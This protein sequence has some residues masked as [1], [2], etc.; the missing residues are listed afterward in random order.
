MTDMLSNARVPA[1]RPRLALLLATALAAGLTAALMLFS[2]SAAASRAR[3]PR[4]GSQPRIARPG[5][6]L[7]G[8]K[9]SSTRAR[10]VCTGVASG[11]PAPSVAHPAPVEVTSISAGGTTTTTTSGGES[12]AAP[13]QAP[14]AGGSPGPA[15]EP[16]G[17]VTDPIDPRYL[18]SLPFGRTS[19]WVQPWRAY[20]DTWPASRLLSSAGVNFNVGA[21]NSDAVA[22]LLHDD[23]FTLARTNLSWNG[24]SYSDPTKLRGDYEPQLRARLTAL[25]EHGLRPLIVLDANSGAP[26]PLKLVTLETLAE[27]PAGAQTVTLS[28]ASA[29]QVVPGKT[30]FSGLVFGGLPD[31]LIASVSSD[32]V[33]TLARPLPEALPAGSHP[34]ATLLYAPFGP[35]T[36]PDGAPNPA[37]QETLA[38]W[39]SYVA[40]VC[41]LASSIFGPGGF[42][43]EVWNEL[44]FGSQFLNSDYYYSSEGGEP[45]SAPEGEPAASSPHRHAITKAVVQA[46]L[47]ATVAY[48]RSPASGLSPEVG[49][50]NGFASETP[51]PSGA[52]A[53]QGLT[54]LSKHPYVGLRSF[55]SAYDVNALRPVNALGLQDT[56]PR[57]P[58]PFTPLFV[59]S[60]ESLLPEYTLTGTST[61]TL[62]R[63]LAPF[64]TDLYGFPHGREVGPAGSP[65][66]QKWVTE[67]NLSLPQGVG[68]G[69]T[70][71]DR[72]HFHAKALLR[73]LVAMVSKGVSRDYFFAAQAGGLSVV[74][75]EFF[76]ALN[77]HPGTYPGDQLGGEITN[78]FHNLLTRFQG[79]GPTGP[80]RQLKL[81][82]IAQDGNHA[83]FTGDGTAG[84]PSLYDREVLAVF[85]YQASPTRFVIPVYVMTR[86]LLTLYQPAA[87]ATETT[88]FDLPNETFRITLANLPET[89]TPPAVSAYDPLHD[90]NTPA[91]LL[92]REG[93]TATFEL[94]A[95]DYPRLL[96]ISYGAGT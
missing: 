82:S 10:R 31:L 84:H 45:G 40:T 36:L 9:K 43:L 83:Q 74:G 13:P 25:R 86:N 37:F 57:E 17:V 85:P 49:I 8:G 69:L 62:I 71:A 77:A 53:P 39:T 68:A 5:C 2:G 54:A 7:K 32:G 79:P 58:P 51:F 75:D 48:V 4:R 44:T 55:P 18:T 59:P 28:P 72:V 95:T 70:P 96:N 6:A 29:A 34:G 73:S 24:L 87:P 89:K 21:R 64:T 91:K 41:R 78:G 67:Y 12:Q 50:T 88:R 15:A 35:P 30:G 20:L 60:Y 52:A 11:A 26:T 56:N 1:A 81:V 76:S 22:Q 61:E 47:R 19:F 33:A 92:H 63:D 14:G 80:A 93:N 3:S 16:G 46:I 66:I 23:G 27:A 65:P 90:Q 38:G 42:D 94:A